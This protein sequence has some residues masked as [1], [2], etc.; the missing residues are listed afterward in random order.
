LICLLAWPA[1]AAL[2][3]APRKAMVEMLAVKYAEMPTAAAITASGALLEVYASKEGATWTILMT[4]PNGLTCL[5][6]AG[7]SW[8]RRKPAEP[9]TKM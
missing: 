7:E 1:Q 2:Q 8:Q 9:G 5:M 4:A 3:C 6:Q